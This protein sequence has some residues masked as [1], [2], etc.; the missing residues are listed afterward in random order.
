[1][2][3][4]VPVWFRRAVVLAHEASAPR[5]FDGVTAATMST[6]RPDF[7]A[8]RA[9]TD[10]CSTTGGTRSHRRARGSRHVDDEVKVMHRLVNGVEQLWSSSIDRLVGLDTRRATLGTK[11]LG[12]D[13]ARSAT[14]NQHRLIPRRT[15][16]GKAST[17]DS[18]TNRSGIRSALTSWPSRATAV[19]EPMRQPWRRRVPTVTEVSPAALTAFAE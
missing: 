9:V 19:A 3:A 11:A 4:G 8:A 15:G 13:V 16:L 6:S 7:I 18:A 1:V 12:Q 14:R 5:D 10:Q 17:R 2:P